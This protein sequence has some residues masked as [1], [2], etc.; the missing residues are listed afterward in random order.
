MA[1]ATHENV[2]VLK[3]RAGAAPIDTNGYIDTD[4]GMTRV[5]PSISVLA[6]PQPIPNAKG[7]KTNDELAKLAAKRKP[8]LKWYDGDEE[9]LF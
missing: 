3:L 7:S 5:L 4:T 2:K 6:I 1:T 9:Q 8:P